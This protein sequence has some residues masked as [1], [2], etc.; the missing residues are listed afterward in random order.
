M[1]KLSDLVDPAAEARLRAAIDQ[2]APSATEAKASTPA[3]EWVEEVG[4]LEVKD[5][6]IPELE[7]KADSGI[8]GAQV[9]EA[10][11]TTGRVVALVSAT[12]V[13]DRV[14]DIIEP[15]AYTKTMLE[16]EPIGV[17]SHDDKT[18]VAR[19]EDAVELMPG[20]PFFADVKTMD[21]KPWPKEAGAVKVEA[22][23][24]LET[25]HG[26]AAFSDVQFFKGKTGWSIGYRA[27]KAMRN[28]RTGV[29]R[30]K[31]LE[32]YE[33]SPVMVGAASQPMTLSIKSMSQPVDADDPT[34]LASEEMIAELTPE[35]LGRFDELKRS[36]GLEV[37]DRVR[38]EDGARKYDQPIGSVIIPD[39]ITGDLHDADLAKMVV[40]AQGKG[41][42]HEVA[43]LRAA[44]KLPPAQ[45]RQA[46]ETGK[47]A[48]VPGG[49]G[50]AAAGAPS[51]GAPAAPEAE[52]VKKTGA[53]HASEYIDASKELHTP[54]LNSVEQDDLRKKRAKIVK[55]AA[56][57]GHQLDEIGLDEKARSSLY[58]DKGQLV[59]PQARARARENHLRQ[60]TLHRGRA[61]E[62]GATETQRKASDGSSA[63]H[64]GEAA[65]Y[66]GDKPA[67]PKAPAATAAERA[68]LEKRAAESGFPRG[69]VPSASDQELRDH[70]GRIKPKAGAADAAPKAQQQTVERSLNVTEREAYNGLSDD[71]KNSYVKA[72]GDGK[73]P[74]QAVHAAKGTTPAAAKLPKKPA[75]NESIHDKV[76]GAVDG[77]PSPTGASDELQGLAD[78]FKK[79][80]SAENATALADALDKAKTGGPVSDELRAHAKRKAGDAPAAPAGQSAEA[81][82]VS[83]SIG[84][85]ASDIDRSGRSDR[86]GQRAE[87]DNLHAVQK[88]WDSGDQKAAIAKFQAYY[89]AHYRNAERSNEQYQYMKLIRSMA[90]FGG[91]GRKAAEDLLDHARLA[92]LNRERRLEGKQLLLAEI[93]E[94]AKTLTDAALAEYADMVIDRDLELE[95]K[96]SSAPLSASTTSNWVA[97]A[98]GLPPYVR[99]VV[100]GVM[101]SGKT[102]EEAIP[103]AIGRIKTWIA[104]GSA[105]TKAKASA[106]LAQ[107]EALKAKNGAKFDSELMLE[108]KAQTL[109]EMERV[110]DAWATL[111]ELKAFEPDEADDVP[112]ESSEVETKTLTMAELIAGRQLIEHTRPLLDTP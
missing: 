55:A 15:G 66:E 79:D 74:A 34:G 52:P 84:N 68:D 61:V 48:S 11:P 110:E 25:P 109:L 62:P 22:L 8:G 23:F 49:G 83:D 77:A 92:Y 45:R 51:G 28:P 46:L 36:L 38:T 29:R 106:A 98:G 4:G 9:L 75:G 90:G 40:A 14:K 105:A 65:K 12:G 13:E 5:S 80:P 101:K 42:E 72:I 88:L 59:D 108:L 60:A 82:A 50:S 89:D 1:T 71:E 31:E 6:G 102:E 107:W 111:Y 27:T 41:D 91:G 7:H 87:V 3:D 53:A 81:K 94:E 96:A 18:W 21:G 86:G 47:L 67:E 69:Q 44:A 39:G 85:L 100:R 16:R 17:W 26:A 78:D 19:T 103:I 70:V 20:D 76:Q 33:Y 95:E 63:F 73:T 10:D 57:D 58:D 56:K 104:T 24:N 64:E 97:R 35:E 54:G 112:E 2:P 32:W 37:K 99:D 43:Q 93:P 30:I